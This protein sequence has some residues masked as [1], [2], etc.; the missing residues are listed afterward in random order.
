MASGDVTDRRTVAVDLTNFLSPSHNIYKHSG[1]SMTIHMYIYIYT[2]ILQRRASRVT[3]FYSQLFRKAGQRPDRPY[4]IEVEK[5]C[6]GTGRR[7]RL[8]HV[9]RRSRAEAVLYSTSLTCDCATL[10]PRGVCVC[11]CVC[12]HVLYGV[13]LC[14][15]GKGEGNVRKTRGMTVQW[16]SKTRPVHNR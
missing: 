5:T 12:E 3:K 1:C 7:W 16:V 8:R 13:G 15:E 11:V 14:G 4:I 6:K 9:R 2:C 10:S